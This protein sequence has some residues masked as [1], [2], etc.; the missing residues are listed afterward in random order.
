V[1]VYF[2]ILIIAALLIALYLWLGKMRYEYLRGLAKQVRFGVNHLEPWER[3]VVKSS[4]V[5]DA[6]ERGDFRG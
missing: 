4:G 2:G 1:I 3:P 6:V 5:Y